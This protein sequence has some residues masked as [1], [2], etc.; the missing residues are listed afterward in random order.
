LDASLREQH[1]GVGVL[2]GAR[3]ALR[4]REI[5]PDGPSTTGP[6]SNSRV[7]CARVGAPAKGDSCAPVQGKRWA[8]LRG[9]GREALPRRRAASLKPR[10]GG[11]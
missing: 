5:L 2:T 6:D 4:V 10:G 3:R 9:L 1:P 11:P 7:G 8:L